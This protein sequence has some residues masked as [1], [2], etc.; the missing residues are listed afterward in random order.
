MDQNQ[1]MLDYLMEMGQL[2]PQQEAITRQRALVDRLREQGQTPGM[3]QAGRLVTA[4]NPLE[5]L[6]AAGSNYMAGQKEQEANTMQDQYKQKRM[7]AL[8][9]M[10]GG[11]G[12]QT[13]PPIIAP[14]IPQEVFPQ[15]Y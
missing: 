1:M 9:R 15:T 7:D 13:T 2:Q 3:R 14:Q 5:F 8:G 12:A 6:G 4:A 11:M 10:R